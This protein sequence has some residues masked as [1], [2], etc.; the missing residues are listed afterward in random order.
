MD[1]TQ[2][3]PRRRRF[4]DHVAAEVADGP[5]RLG[6]DGRGD[7]GSTL[8][9]V[10][11]IFVTVMAFAGFAVDVGIAFNYRRQAQTAVD[12]GALAG[13]VEAV[14]QN[15]SLIGNTAMRDRIINWVKY[16][17]WQD[18][19]K[20]GNPT[21]AEWNTAW[22]NCTDSGKLATT[23]PAAAA[24]T[25]LSNPPG[26]DWPAGTA[27]QCISWNATGSK[28]RVRLPTQSTPTIFARLV[29]FNTYQ[30]SAVAEVDFV[31]NYP[32]GG[33]LPFGM[34]GVASTWGEVCATSGAGNVPD[35]LCAHPT[36][37][38]FG[39]IDFKLF[40]NPSIGNTSD[41]VNNN[42]AKHITYNTVMG[43]DH[44]LGLIPNHQ[45]GVY[46]NSAPIIQEAAV[47]PQYLARPNTFSTQ[48]GNALIAA[49]E[50]GMITGLTAGYDDFGVGT[51]PGR[52]QN[53]CPYTFGSTTPIGTPGYC[54][55]KV[56]KNGTPAIDDVG[57]WQYLSPQ[58]TPG[59]AASQ[60][61]RSCN[62]LAYF[63]ATP[64]Y[65][66]WKNFAP[67]NDTRLYSNQSKEHMERCF[68]DYVNGIY[69]YTNNIVTTPGGY[70]SILFGR[71]SDGDPS[72]GIYDIMRSPRFGHVP[73]FWEQ[74]PQSG[75][76]AVYHLRY[77][78]AIYIETMYF[79][80]NANGCDSAIAPG[81]V[82]T[83][84][85]GKRTWDPVTKLPTFVNWA[86][87]ASNKNLD[88]MTAM[89]FIF[90]SMLP[91]EARDTAFTSQNDVGVYLSK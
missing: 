9:V 18:A 43:V 16:T 60:V 12:A 13:G 87:A 7:R 50:K 69:D 90:P 88:A 56:Y 29:G 47:C 81:E 62:I 8:P 41:C 91:E 1:A 57:I 86:P 68:H 10:L 38:N 14:N 31:L 28:M 35:P 58:M 23:A 5:G 82:G 22:A 44:P 45:T 11:V 32:A 65:Y 84:D 53:T 75:Q 36:D 19:L 3:H 66:A 46:D 49:T 30:T 64:T 55:K 51:R 20:S 76:S 25:S 52:L 27:T 42:M 78:R 37:G 39:Y 4:V 72:N 54:T 26:P 33:V 89:S 40:G 67:Y 80:C 15:Q 48:T 59:T 2:T 71:D 34:W 24:T 70:Q 17:T 74:Q 79:G 61:P 6:L 21:K 77:R 85:P 73:L 83:A 63:P